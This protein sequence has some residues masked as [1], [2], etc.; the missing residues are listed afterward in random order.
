MR[1]RLL[2]SL[3]AAVLAFFPG[4]VLAFELVPISRQFESSG[5]GATQTYELVNQSR[6]YV[7]VEMRTVSRQIDANGTETLTEAEDD[8]LIFPAQIILD[9]G[10]RQSVRVSYI[11]DPA[12][13]RE[14]AYRLV[15]EQLPI[16]GLGL[17]LKAPENAE[18]SGQVR[19]LMKYQGSLYV[20]PPGAR[21]KLQ[22]V[23]AAG[24]KLHDGAAQ[25]DL[26]LANVGTARAEFDDHEIRINSQEKSSSWISLRSLKAAAIM[27]GAERQVTLPWPAKLPW[28]K[29]PT[30]EIRS[31]R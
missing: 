29:Q 7:A 9:P 25:L 15:A 19:V 3:F 10:A 24:K 13:S 20:R 22:V 12:P 26:K 17:P 1:H 31:R 8:F 18:S 23:E 30:V 14:L 27:A 5:S 16:E 11:G 28:S 4:A 21:A 6:E 2:A